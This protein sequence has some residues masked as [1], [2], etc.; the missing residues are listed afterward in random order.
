[1]RVL[2]TPWEKRNLDVTGVEYYFEQDDKWEDIPRDVLDDTVH[3]YQVAY[4]PVNKMGIHNVL[5]ENGFRFSEARFE[6]VAD[7]RKLELPQ[8]FRRMDSMLSYRSVESKEE[9]EKIYASMKSGVFDTDKV[10]LDPYM[11]IEK[12]GYRYAIWS[13]QLIE[14]KKAFPYVVEYEDEIIGFFILKKSSEKIGDSFLAALFDNEKYNGFGFSV[15]YYPMLEA[16][17]QGMIKMITGV[18]SNNLSSL[19]MHLALGYQ[20]R[21]MSYVMIKHMI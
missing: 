18:S 17:R 15:L 5:N 6:I 4:L 14:E 13:K 20:I 8:V 9:L 7:I 16:K 11:G 2:E 19:K 1:M 21:N 12:S 3:N 10:A